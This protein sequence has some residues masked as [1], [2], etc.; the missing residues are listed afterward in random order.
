MIA[1]VIII[2]GTLVAAAAF[3]NGANLPCHLGPVL[4]WI[5]TVMTLVAATMQYKSSLPFER[6]LLH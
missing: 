5:G 4:G 6:R 1:L 2:V 3:G